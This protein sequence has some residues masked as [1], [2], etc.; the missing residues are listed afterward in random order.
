MQY[1]ISISPRI[2]NSPRACA[3][4]TW[5]LHRELLPAP[6]RGRAHTEQ[7]A[8]GLRRGR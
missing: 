2:S 8:L 7:M 6:S 5:A 3:V 4:G 1:R